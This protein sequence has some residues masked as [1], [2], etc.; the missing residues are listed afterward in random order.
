VVRFGLTMR[1]KWPPP[2]VLTVPILA[3]LPPFGFAQIS[4]VRFERCA[5]GSLLDSVPLS[6]ALPPCRMDRGPDRL[7]LVGYSL[8]VPFAVPPLLWAETV[9]L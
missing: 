3:H 9:T 6:L 4:I 1:E 8:S 5:F 7:S 2:L